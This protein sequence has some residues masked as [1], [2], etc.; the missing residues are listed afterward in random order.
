MCAV[1]KKQLHLRRVFVRTCFVSLLFIWLCFL[2]CVLSCPAFEPIGEKCEDLYIHIEGVNSAAR[3]ST[4]MYL[5]EPAK[6]RPRSTT[7]I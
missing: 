1:V 6:I 5:V 3:L 7:S 2:F 4:E